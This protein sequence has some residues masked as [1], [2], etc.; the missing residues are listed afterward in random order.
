[1]RT[2]AF[3]LVMLFF[4]WAVVILIDDATRVIMGMHQ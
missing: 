3:G 1:M 4:A 2:V